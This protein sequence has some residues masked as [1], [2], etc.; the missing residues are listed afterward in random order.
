[1]NKF[2]K[3]SIKS[4]N[5]KADNYDDTLDG[6]FTLKFNLM[7]AE[8]VKIN[9]ND[10]VLDI[11]CGNG[12][13]LNMLAKKHTF[14]G[15]GSDISE[16]MIE[17]AKKYN[18][19]MTFAVGRCEKLPFETA[20]FDVVTVCAAYHHFPEVIGFANE[21]RRLLKENGRLYIAEIYQPAFIRA[22]C[23]PFMSL[24]R[25]GDVKFYSP[26]EILNMLISA[27]YKNSKCKI[28]GNVQIISAYR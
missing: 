13:F 8:A 17:Q 14:N 4:Y 1:M 6:R 24:S 11:A 21:A 16:K 5:K 18:P 15:F 27:G 12:R 25:A 28:N 3:R 10:N 26:D 19:S 9:A 20:M 22:I 7:L 2:E 23:N